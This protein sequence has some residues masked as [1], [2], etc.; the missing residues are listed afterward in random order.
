MRTIAFVIAG[1]VLGVF[2]ARMRTPPSVHV[3]S[4]SSPPPTAGGALRPQA[5]DRRLPADHRRIPQRDIPPTD[6]RYNPVAL[7]DEKPE[8]SLKEIFESEPRDVTF[9]PV[10][11]KR[12]HDALDTIVQELRLENTVR[13]VRTECR[14]LSCYTII[15]VASAD[16]EQVYD[17]INGIL[18]G[19]TQHPGVSH[20]AGPDHVTAVTFY[21]IYR[22]ETRDDT[23]YYKEFLV[24]AM[25]FPLDLAKKKYLKDQAG[26]E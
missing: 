13:N 22:P 14:T 1:M 3:T 21:N 6:I 5:T 7:Q 8:L 10:M 19:D 16:L 26:A 20:N 4:T 15:E 18:I 2:G 11:E 9:A 24:K 17:E 23:Y 12:V 25:R